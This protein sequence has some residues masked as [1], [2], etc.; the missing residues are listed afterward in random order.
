[1]E[2]GFC[3]ETTNSNGPKMTVKKPPLLTESMDALL[4]NYR[5][6]E[7]LIGQDNILKQHTKALEVCLTSG[8]QFKTGAIQSY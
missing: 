6:P 5:K 2:T 1:M 4:A 7:D 3:K 8:G